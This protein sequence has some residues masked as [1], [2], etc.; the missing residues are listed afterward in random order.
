MKKPNEW[1]IP[2]GPWVLPPGE[3]DF[4]VPVEEYCHYTRW[5]RFMARVMR[6]R[7]EVARRKE[8]RA[9]FFKLLNDAL[10]EWE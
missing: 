9:R 4:S 5:E 6:K 3:H 1:L 8:E 2:P 7:S 10:D